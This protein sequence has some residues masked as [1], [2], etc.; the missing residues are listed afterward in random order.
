MRAVH[1]FSFDGDPYEQEAESVAARV[2]GIP[3][4]PHQLL[5]SSPAA[6]Q[7]LPLVMRS[8][9]EPVFGHD[10]SRVRVHNDG[11][12]AESA[13]E[14]NAQAYTTGTDIKFGSGQY[15]PNT[16]NGRRL[17]AHEL[18]HVV[19]QQSGK[20]RTDRIQCRN[21]ASPRLAGNPRFERVLDNRSVIEI[22]DRGPEVRRIQQLL[23]DLGFGLGSFGAD[24]RFGTETETAVK[25]FQ[26]VHGLADDGRVGFA[27]MNALDAEFPSFALPTDKS[28]PWTMPCVL[29]ILCPWN[30]HL[31][32]DVLPTFNIITFDSRDF[33]R[34][35]W[36]GTTWISDTFHSGGFTNAGSRRMGFLNDTTCEE[37]AFTI[38]HEGWHGQQPTSLTGVVDSERDAYINAEQ[39]SIAMGVPGQTF[40]DTSTGNPSQSLRTTRAGETIVDEPAAERLVRQGY[41][42]VS[43]APGET[44]LSRVGASDVRVQRPDGSEYN[45]P[46][47]RGESV[48]GAVSMPNQR[49]ITPSEWVCP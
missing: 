8:F 45:R 42:G 19:Q 38:Y 20:V 24:G 37:M 12:A 11:N 21:L 9:M 3:P 34:Q 5:S 28:D 10:F 41:A 16:E 6:G 14:L 1:D 18:T 36:N 4:P 30:R 15:A 17:L 32:E 44:V 23:I 22:G 49:A 43:S 2:A 25:E 46:A 31:V 48:R 29:G 27:T 47:Q 26:R 35:T 39:W 40:D 7:P 13:R 33:P